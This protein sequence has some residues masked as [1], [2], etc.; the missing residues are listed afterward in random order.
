MSYLFQLKQ[1]ERERADLGTRA[2]ERLARMRQQWLAWNETIP[3]IPQDAGIS[4]G[5]SCKDMPQ[6]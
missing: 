3:P 6:R 1:D 2:S 5:Y 4:V